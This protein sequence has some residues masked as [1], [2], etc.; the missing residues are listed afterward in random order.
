MPAD[1]CKTC[2]GTELRTVTESVTEVL[3]YI[4]GRFEV[5]LLV[6]HPYLAVDTGG[7][8]CLRWSG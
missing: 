3:E 2:G 4:P 6:V 1:V 5:I 8:A 7:V